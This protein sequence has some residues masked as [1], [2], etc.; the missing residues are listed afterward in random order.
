MRFRGTDELSAPTPL[1]LDASALLRI[2]LGHPG[3]RAPIGRGV[4]VTSSELVLIEA[5][6]TLEAMRLE[7][8][9]SD[10]ETGLKFRDLERLALDAHLFPVSSEVI[11]L[12]RASFPLKVRAIH[13]VHV[14]TAQ[15]IAGEVGAL[16]MWTHHP[17]QAAAAA[18]RGIEVRGVDLHA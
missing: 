10:L 12:A 16:E 8:R 14:A 4:V 17:D 13:A 15:V 2:L 6:R 3:P 1:Y 11:A 18:S 9:L 5:S 7:R